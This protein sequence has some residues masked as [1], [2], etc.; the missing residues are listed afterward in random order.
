VKR[1]KFLNNA[2]GRT[3]ERKEVV[4][5]RE[6]IGDGGRSLK[7]VEGD[8]SRQ[9]GKKDRLGGTSSR[10]VKVRWRKIKRLTRD[11]QIYKKNKG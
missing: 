8:C 4:S 6:K 2:G 7:L 3:K 11:N 10:K 9:A 1:S 5:Y